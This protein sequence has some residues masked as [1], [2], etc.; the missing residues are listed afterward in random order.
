MNAPDS[1]PVPASV[2][3]SVLISA[4]NEA[5][6]LARCLASLS[7][8]DEIVVIDSGSA[9]A[10]ARIAQSFGV[11]VESFTWN[12][13]YPKK[14]QWCLENL[15]LK[16]EWVFFV[17]A[18]EVIP[19]ALAQEIAA[20]MHAPAHEG[21]FV[22]GLYVV[23][24]RVLRHGARN[25]KLVLFRRAAFAFPVVNDLGIPGMGEME[26]HY[27]PVPVAGARI[28]RLENPMLHYAYE[29]GEDWESRHRRYAVWEAGMNRRNAWPADPVPARQRLKALFRR[30][31]CR[32][33]IAFTHSYIYKAGFLD[34]R[35][36]FALAR[37][38]YRYYRLVA[39]SRQ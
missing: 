32:G 22:E 38:R 26:G 30:L 19:P 20:L 7:A 36:G 4:R 24:G 25:S 6:C 8:F 37:D 3:V 2:P 13:R 10:T 39:R 28:G 33:V 9:D 1:A 35:A 34:G 15:A 29:S 31:P 18:D 21:Y 27:Q 16:H 17:D 23:Q 5:A 11:R 14:R 12:G